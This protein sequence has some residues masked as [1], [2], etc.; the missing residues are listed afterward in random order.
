MSIFTKA[1]SRMRTSLKH[2]YYRLS[3]PFNKLRKKFFIENTSVICI[4]VSSI[5][6]HNCVFCG[7]PKYEGKKIIMDNNTFADIVDK[8]TPFGY[9]TIHL[10][11]LTGEVFTDKNF[12]DKLQILEDNPHI[13]SY[14]FTSNFVPI[15]EANI[16]KLA[17]MN[18]MSDIKISV[19]GHDRES[20]KKLTKSSDS[21]YD[22]FL[23]NLDSLYEEAKNV[24]YKIAF[25][26]RTYDGVDISDNNH[27]ICA[28]INRFRDLPNSQ[29]DKHVHYT[30]WGGVVSENDVA[31][32]DIILKDDKT[33]YKNGPCATIFN[34]MVTSQGKLV[35]C[36]CR[37]VHRIL[38][39][40][41]LTVNSLSDIV[42][43]DNPK[44]MKLIN[45]QM[46]NIYNPPC[47]DC[48]M[49]RPVLA[50]P[51]YELTKRTKHATWLSLKEYF[52]KFK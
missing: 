16:K 44:F 19:Y 10:T 36:A 18:K 3:V 2:N 8:V 15:T 20:F 49:Y 46:D 31:D 6:N 41:D 30:N 17:Q 23:K 33:G 14:S 40:G 7:Y 52:N 25:G 42:S 32:V 12:L 13:K 28:S 37:D 11:P 24:K 39:I 26:F 47:K 43:Q 29:I 1:R 21:S 9:D 50:L 48:D 5:C 27:E 22:M 45:D 4:E 38:E 35:V 51:H 34:L